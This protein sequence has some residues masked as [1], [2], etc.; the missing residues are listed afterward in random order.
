MFSCTS[1]YS[2]EHEEAIVL[3]NH[4]LVLRMCSVVHYAAFM[5]AQSALGASE[6]SPEQSLLDQLV[7]FQTIQYLAA[8]T[9]GPELP[10][11]GVPVV[12]HHLYFKD[13]PLGC[14]VSGTIMGNNFWLICS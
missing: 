8:N 11:E 13:G 1:L 14:M 10:P 2:N 6:L 4:C 12:P 7:Q 3:S 9:A 5:F